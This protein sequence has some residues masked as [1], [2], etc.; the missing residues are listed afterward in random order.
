MIR[1]RIGMLLLCVGFFVPSCATE[2]FS[3]DTNIRPSVPWTSS[4]VVGLTIDLVDSNAIESMTF[5]DTGAVIAT[6]GRKGGPVAG[7]VFYWSI[8]S[9]RLLL[10]DDDKKVIDEFTL[11]WRDATAVVVQR[12]TGGLALFSIRAKHKS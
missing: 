12:R 4:S 9:G 6:W 3:Q 2:R 11:L 8:D 7:P 10:T 5:T 1:L